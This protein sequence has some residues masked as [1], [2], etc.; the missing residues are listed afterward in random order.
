ME[1]RPYDPDRDREGL[2]VLKRAFERELGAA[3]GDADRRATYEDKLTDEYRDRYLDWVGRCTAES[4]A[5]VSVTAVDDE[6]VGYTFLLPA[7]LALIWD[8]AVLNE[9]YV[10]PAHRG[11]GIADKLL[12]VVLDV[13]RGQSLPMD[14]VVL[15]V[16]PANARA[17]A[18]YV[19][20]GFEPWGELVAREL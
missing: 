18:F 1:T 9:I 10:A 16:A 4:P 15:D 20:H 3:A 8:A 12:E 6:L 17:R 7:S 14:R 19:R 11:T 5:C 2:W 13:A